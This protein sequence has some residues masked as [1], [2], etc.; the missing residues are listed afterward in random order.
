[1]QSFYT[2][3]VPPFERWWLA[4]LAINKLFENLG[5]AFICCSVRLLSASYWSCLVVVGVN[6]ED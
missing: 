3:A 6:G 5:F 1:V 4:G 2:Y